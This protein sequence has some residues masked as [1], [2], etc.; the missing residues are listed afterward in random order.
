MRLP[1]FKLERYFAEYEFKVRHL[2]SA[3][4]CESLALPDLL[5]LADAETRSLWEHLWLGY[6]ES[7]GH[8]LLR[9]EIARLY[10][11]IPPERVL[12]AVPEEAIFISMNGLLD[13]GDE[14]IVTWP[15]YQSLAE[16]AAAIGSQVVRWPLLLRDGAWKLDAEA[17]S[18]LITPRT[19]MVVV[20]FPHNPTG[21]QPS[22][23]E[24]DAIIEVVRGA[25][26]VL[27]SDEMYRGLEMP[28]VQRLPSA[29]DC[30]ARGVTL[31]G[32][33]KSYGLPGLRIG[34]LAT[35]DRDV[36]RRAGGIKDYTTICSSAPSEIL[37]IIAL[38]AGQTIVARNTG[39]VRHNCGLAEAFF[40]ARPDA[41]EWLLPMAGS[42][43]FP[44]LRL[45]MTA[46][47]YAQE[48]LD[49]RGVMIAPGEMFEMPG[50]FRVGLGR[51]SFGEALAALGA[52]G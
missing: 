46:L 21:Y 22:R 49:T 35:H 32:L 27:F 3:S 38:R 28:G 4:D 13:P 30:A 1:P 51:R 37:G 8:P 39:I 25:G 24:W 2:L 18:R 41:V 40:G 47:A 45:P 12:V 36:L 52:A 26:A 11:E 5:A 48:C 19:R 43:A 31:S 50:H 10:R 6:T 16:V 9:S 42:V 34:W 33:S 23:P 15:A 44:Q 20:N 17:L 7:E 29:C 14:V